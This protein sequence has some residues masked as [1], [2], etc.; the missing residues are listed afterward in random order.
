MHVTLLGTGS[1]DGWPNPFCTCA[2]CNSAHS[3]GDV[4]GQ[5]SI[6]VDDALLID[7][8]PEAPR[9][10]MRLGRRL[11]RVHTL[12]FTHTHPDHLDPVALLYRQ[13]SNSTE[14]LHVIGPAAVVAQ[15]EQ[16]VGPNDPVSMTTVQ[17]GDSLGHRGYRVRV[18]AA[19]HDGPEVG[20]AVVYDIASTD[21]ARLLFASDTGPLSDQTHAAIGGAEFDIALIE[22]TFDGQRNHGTDHLDRY[23]FG[24][25]IARLRESRAITDRTQTVAVHLSH[26]NPPTE[27]LSAQ[28]EQM[29]VLVLADGATLHSGAVPREPVPNSP[30][31][32]HRTL[33]LGGARS[34]KSAHAEALLLGEPDV[35]YVATAPHDPEDPEWQE[36]IARH[37]ARRPERWRTVETPDL[38]SVLVKAGPDTTLL[39][40]CLTLWLSQMLDHTAAW[41][42]GTARADDALAQLTTAWRQTQARVV[43]VSNEVGSG[44]VPPTSAGRLFRDFQGRMNTQLAADSDVV[45]MVVAGRTIP[46]TPPTSQHHLPESR[47]I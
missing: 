44:V 6:L 19:N 2:S 41:T 24:E 42:S 34:G 14:P 4:R 22:R 43:A 39:I 36:R 33:I 26:H 32:A 12:L 15:C 31:K 25:T 35:T 3:T 18:H 13:W 23:T 11:D 27:I 7:C 46:L 17:P 5:T 47:S 30:G 16:W 45:T 29:G 21:G 28:L 9:S 1:A 37:R 40:D 20:P 38:A 8:G 10:A